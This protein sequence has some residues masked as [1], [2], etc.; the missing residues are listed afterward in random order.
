M[1]VLAGSINYRSGL[2]DWHFVRHRITG[3]RWLHRDFVHGTSKNYEKTSGN[4]RGP[5]EI[6]IFVPGSAIA[7][8]NHGAYKCLHFAVGNGDG[9]D[10]RERCKWFATI[11]SQISE[12]EASSFRFTLFVLCL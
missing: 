3:Q 5:K 2:R 12:L 1:L 7:D 10:G 8:G 4:F 11:L 9:T 6:R